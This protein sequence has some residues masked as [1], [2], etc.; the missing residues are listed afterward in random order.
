MGCGCNKKNKKTEIQR[1]VDYSPNGGGTVRLGLKEQVRLPVRLPSAISGQDIIVV[2]NK[3]QV[4]PRPEVPVGSK[5]AFVIVG[6]NAFVDI[7][8]KEQLMAKWPKAFNAA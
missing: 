2:A 3:T 4:V 7:E 5:P 6:R 8:H 1:S